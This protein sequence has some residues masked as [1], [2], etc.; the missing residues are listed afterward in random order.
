[1]SVSAQKTHFALKKAL[2]EYIETQYFGKNMLLKDGLK[3]KLNQEGNLFHEPYIEV[4]A[5]YQ[6][7]KDGIAKAG[8][9]DYLQNFLQK[10]AQAKLGVY[11]T[12]FQ[13]QVEALRAYQKG[14][15]IFVSTGTGSGNTECFMWPLLLKLV[16]EAKA[17]PDSWR[18]RGVRAILMYPMNALVSDQL[19]R[20]RRMVGDPNGEFMSIFRETVGTS[21]RRPQFGMY[22]GRTPYPDEFPNEKK[23]HQLANMLSRYLQSSG[24]K[25]SSYYQS[26]LKEGKIPAKKDFASFIARLRQSVHIPDPDDAELI[27]RFEMQEYTPD[28]LITNYSMMEYMMI[29]PREKKIWENTVD[30]LEADPSN[31]LLFIMDEAH[32]YRGSTGGEVALLLRRLF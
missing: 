15:D 5:A 26:L 1:M 12:P 4:S 9:P 21:A 10:L 2:E 17:S 31:K 28:I 24:S 8:L 6:V 14:K 23:D 3:G 25:D 7:V 16:T 19:S 18:Q 29:R 13:H 20:L 32:M 11:D 27:T 30:W 22:T